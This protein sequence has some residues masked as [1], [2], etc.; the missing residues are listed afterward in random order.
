MTRLAIVI[1]S[2]NTRGDLCDCLRSLHAAPPAAT[3]RI[4]VA[5][6]ASSDGSAQ[7][8]RE[9]WPAVELIKMGRNAGFA[10][11][12]NA[13]IRATASEMVLLLNSDT[14]VPPGSLD[15]LIARLDGDPGAVAAGPRLIGA[16]GALELSFGRMISP[17]NEARQKCRV[18][19]LTHGPGWLSL[20][21]AR[22]AEREHHPDWV[23]GA[24]LLVRRAAG[25]A[26]GWLD[27]R[28]FLYGEAVDFCAAL[29]AAGGRILFTPDAEVIHRRGRSG[30]T[31]PAATR[32]AY[33]RSHL[34][35]YAKHHARWLPLLRF[36]LRLRGELP[37]APSRPR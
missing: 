8:V 13:G 7:A 21:I 20:R 23:S 25:D 17:W 1:V 35:F 32:A 37:E 27:E 33:R 36:Y 30:S 2:Y 15:R 14:L 19:A 24:C 26:A 16:D 11:A 31:N 34:A 12:N 3:H 5:D 28:F 4:V 9:G 29:R 18:R 22:L 10:A 6:N